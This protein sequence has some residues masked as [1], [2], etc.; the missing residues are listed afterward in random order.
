MKAYVINLDSRSDRWNSVLAQEKNL[1]LPLVR[2][3]AV[4]TNEVSSSEFTTL[5]VNATWGSHQRAMRLF[6]A[7]NDEYGLILEDDFILSPSWSKTTLDRFQTLGCDFL[8]VG[9]LITTPLDLIEIKLKSTVDLALKLLNKLTSMGLIPKSWFGDRLLVMEQDNVPFSFV[10]NDI[11]PGAH[12]YIVS[13]RFAMASQQF[14]NPVILSTDALFMALGWM[15]TFKFMR[16][17]KSV[18]SQSDSATS[19]T[20]RFLS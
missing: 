16:I 19:I 14:N 12:G 13:R 6:L 1:A 17:R 4:S 8:Q 2:V 3:P 15:R 11:R 7:S 5:A 20:E 10:C 9:Y 18:I